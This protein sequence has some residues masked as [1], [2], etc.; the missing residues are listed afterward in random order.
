[1]NNMD[2]RSAWDFCQRL[3]HKI[4]SNKHVLYTEQL[5]HLDKQ[6]AIEVVQRLNFAV[7]ENLTATAGCANYKTYGVELSGPIFQKTYVLAQ[8]IDTILH[9]IAHHL[10]FRV[11][12]ER[13]HGE[14]WIMWAEMI[15]CSAERTHTMPR[16]RRKTKAQAA[17]SL[18]NT[19]KL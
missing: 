12:A 18:R 19:L 13:G 15:G 1:M 8:V 16:A 17:L 3:S 10:A 7:N 2:A 4:I 9:E 14:H 11:N 5:S 6:R